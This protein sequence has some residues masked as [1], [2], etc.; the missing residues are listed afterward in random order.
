MINDNNICACIITYNPEIIRLK[1][2]INA[3]RDQVKE[4]IVID[5]NSDNISD[6]EEICKL[7]NTIL[8]KNDYNAGIAKALNQAV[9]WADQNGYTWVL[10]LDQ[11]S[12]CSRQIVQI[13][14]KYIDLPKIGIITC[15]I[16]DI[17]SGSVSE[18]NK[19]R[20]YF[21]DKCITSGSFTNISAVKEVGGFDESFFIDMVDDDIC[22]SLAEKGYRILRVNHIGL[23]H[24]IGKSKMYSIGPIKF[25][26]TNHNSKRKYTITRNSIYLLKKHNLNPA[27]VYFVVFKRVFTVLLFERDKAEKVKAILNGIIDGRQYNRTLK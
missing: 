12:I 23:Y 9:D 17:N 25:E 7:Y 21:I 3:I 15:R 19:R 22:Y 10:T 13:Y 5:N 20:V 18:K 4:L 16:K 26:V 27:I 11:D 14:K 1:K 24:E 6:I 2:N 8:I